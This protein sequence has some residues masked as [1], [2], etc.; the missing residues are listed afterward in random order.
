MSK[1]SVSRRDGAVVNLML[2]IASLSLR[3]LYESRLSYLPGTDKNHESPLRKLRT[4]GKD[5]T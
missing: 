2:G 1:D 3:G 4:D 5:D